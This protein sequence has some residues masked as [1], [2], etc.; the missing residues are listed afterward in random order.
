[1]FT[2]LATLAI[3]THPANMVMTVI[4]HMI[5]FSTN[6]ERIQN[7]LLQAPVINSQDQSG[8]RSLQTQTDIVLENVTV[9]DESRP[10]LKDITLEMPRG[11]VNICCGKVGSGKSVLSRLLLG[12]LAASSG[13]VARPNIRIGYCAQNAWIPSGTIRDIICGFSTGGHLSYEE[14]VQACCLNIDISR[15]PSRD[16]TPIG[17]RGVNLSGGQKQRVV[18]TRSCAI[19]IISNTLRLL[20]DCFTLAPK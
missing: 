16:L 20:H 8:T 19:L 6:F 15:L 11:S 14:V 3:V 7:Y 1:M 4:P 13:V 18:S 12:E 2:T 9:G 10:S 5:S 17:S